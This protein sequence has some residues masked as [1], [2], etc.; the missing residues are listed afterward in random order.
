MVGAFGVAQQVIM[1]K[2]RVG[3][4]VV[5]ALCCWCMLLAAAGCSRTRYRLAADRDA[6]ALLA[7][8]SAGRPWQVP[9]RFSVYPHP[10]SR[11]FDPTPDDDPLLPV[12]APRLYAYSLPALPER[13]PE[14]F[15]GQASTSGALAGGVPAEARISD[16]VAASGELPPGP[17]PQAG[18][19][20]SVQQV[21]FQP[22]PA[23]TA[24]DITSLDLE[25][26]S[27]IL[28]MEVQELQILP[29]PAA[30]WESLPERCLT[31]MLE[32]ASVR[33]EYRRTFTR[34]PDEAQ[35]DSSQRLSLEDV[36]QLALINSREYQAQKEQLYVKA[37]TL[38]LQRFD[39]DLKFATSGNGTNVNYLD[40]P[41]YPGRQGRMLVR[42]PVAVERTLA[43]GGTFLA[44]FANDI[45]LTFNGAS[46]FSADVGSTLLFDISQT[47]FQRDFL[48]EQLTQA[49]RDVVYQARTF[50]RARKTLFRDLA[51]QYYNLLLTYRGIEIVSQDY[52]SNLRGFNQSEA[53]YRAGRL[54]RFQVDQFEQSTLDS[55]S[56]LISSCNDLEE[57]LDQ[58]KLAIGLPPELPLNLDLTELD[59]LT[60][61]DE[62]T[63]V[64]ERVRR[65][66]RNVINERGLQAPQRGALLN[67][68]VDLVRKMLLVEQLQQRLGEDSPH[69]GPLQ[70][71]LAQLAAAE[72]ELEVQ[73]KR[74][75]LTQDLQADP[76]APPLRIFQR[77]TDLLNSQLA[78]VS[79]QLRVTELRG[80]DSSHRSPLQQ[81]AD[82]LRRRSE[83]MQTDL[84]Q[85]IVDRDLGRIPEFVQLAAGLLSEVD[86]VQTQLQ[87]LLPPR[88]ADPNAALQQT[89]AD[90]D[91]L[92]EQSQELL[93]RRAGGLTP[94][95]VDVDD[96]MLT[97]LTLRYE[98]MNQRESLADDWRNI[99]YQG[100]DLKS[101][102]NLHASELLRTRRDANRPF[103]FSWDD[104]DTELGVTFDAPL[105]R[106]SQ[107]NSFRRSLIDYNVGLRNLMDKED[108]I[109]FDVR[110]SLRALALAQEQYRIAVA[111]AA[112]AYE[113]RISTRLQL[114]LGVE[115]IRVEDVLDAQRAYTRSLNSLAR[116]HITY[117]LDRI[118]L[119]MDLELL[120]VDDEG[121]W[122]HLYDEDYQPTP[123]LQLP[124]YAVPVYGQLPRGVWP[125]HKIKRMLHVP[126][127]QTLIYQTDDS[128]GTWGEEVPAP[129]PEDGA[130]GGE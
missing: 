117:V 20:A 97:A 35:R 128:E 33:D 8:K 18:P 30:I 95:E 84:D 101:V 77:T 73:F 71:E 105:N 115:N 14:R 32:F 121:F 85:V 63:A 93:A 25:Q 102:L 28:G 70:L 22:P 50:A 88:V 107:R 9:P 52:F 111:S 65:A 51:R 23:D 5:R 1:A 64:A 66:R 19:P 55:R 123:N 76:A 2:N 54:P 86:A 119:F 38:S 82:D 60:L 46:G 113:R 122:Q 34:E 41:T 129:L 120:E 61:R 126:P 49:E 27:L 78:L 42:T 91:R 31:R 87:A 89:L 4:L 81:R 43:T 109:K 67:A 75:V 108:R 29:V 59:Q 98:L 106:R 125:S 104:S 127:G 124:D 7:E 26:L 15:R 56:S 13:S 36:L 68:A 83:Q 12:P 80:L 62:V 79:R 90:V 103:D 96:A 40:S 94:I 37:L 110:T 44:R 72:A 48:L 118:G 58:L 100:D 17:S 130:E 47:V 74:D 53:E 112:L 69:I 99:K 10:Q 24:Q 45:V 21:A 116:T 11:F 6:A 57:G 3:W 114:R 16:Q 39:Y 92:I